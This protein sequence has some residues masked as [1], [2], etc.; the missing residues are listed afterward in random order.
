MGAEQSNK[1]SAAERVGE[2]TDL[3]RLTQLLCLTQE[4]GGPLNV[5]LGRM[6]SLA[7]RNADGRTARSLDAVATQAQRLVDLRVEILEVIR[8][9]IKN[10]SPMPSLKAVDAPCRQMPQR[11]VAVGAGRSRHAES[12][13]DK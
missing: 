9:L 8:L 5:V 7:A 12:V 11:A 3:D 1:A 10:A 13:V 4:M 6:E 2:T